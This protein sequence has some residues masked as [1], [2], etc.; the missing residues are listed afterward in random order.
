MYPIF[1]VDDPDA[2]VP[3]NSMPGQSRYGV[4][5]LIP[6][7]SPLVEKGLKAVLLFGV[8]EKLEKDGIGSAADQKD[9]P[10]VLAIQKLRKTFPQ[11]VVACDVCL[12]P[13]SSHGHCGI[14]REDGSI[15]NEPSIARLAEIAVIY[16]KAGCQIVAPSDMM[17]GRVGAIKKALF[18]AGFSNTVALM[19]YS[20]KFASSFYGPFRDAANCAPAFGDRKCYQFPPGAVGLAERAADRDVAEGADFLMVKPGM[21]YLD[22]C[23][24][25]KQKHPTHPLAIY[26]VSGEYAMLYHAAEKGAFPL[27]AAV[28]E[29]LQSMR[30]AGVDILITYYTPQ[31]LDWI[32]E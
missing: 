2:V 25:I 4:N 21:P 31:V 26:H 3:I 1:I 12:C 30:R 18:D 10:V 11:L 5:A 23:R 14:L 28:M 29:S 19:S 13:Y 9:S 17:D 24:L 16:A 15:D 7:L 20:A 22:I 27:K 6:A 32:Q 8:P